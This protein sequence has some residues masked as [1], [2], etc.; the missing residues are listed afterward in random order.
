M[1][2]RSGRVFRPAPV[3]KSNLTLGM[4]PSFVTQPVRD[5]ENEEGPRPR[6]LEANR[7]GS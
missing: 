3:A 4:P 5:G 7:M 2:V 6:R 1:E